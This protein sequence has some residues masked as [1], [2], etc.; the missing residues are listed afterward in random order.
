LQ[1]RFGK[2]LFF[3]QEMLLLFL[4]LKETLIKKATKKTYLSHG[5]AAPCCYDTANKNIRREMPDTDKR[6]ADAGG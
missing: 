6:R 4:T 2:K 5:F 3:L 1:V